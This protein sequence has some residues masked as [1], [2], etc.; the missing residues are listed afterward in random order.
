MGTAHSV[1]PATNSTNACVGLFV[2]QPKKVF[3]TLCEGLPQ[4][5]GAELI[6]SSDSQQEG[7]KKVFFISKLSA[8][9]IMNNSSDLKFRKRIRNKRR[10]RRRRILALFHKETLLKPP[11]KPRA[12]S[13]HTHIK[14]LP[15]TVSWAF[16]LL[17]DDL[18]SHLLYFFCFSLSLKVSAFFFSECMW[19]FIHFLPGFRLDFTVLPT[20][21]DKH[22][23]WS[24][25]I[26]YR[27]Q[28]ALE[29]LPNNILIMLNVPR[30]LLRQGAS[31]MFRQEQLDSIKHC[32]GKCKYQ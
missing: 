4:E 28:Q 7:E 16:S 3:R 25:R 24:V 13:T 12:A 30:R 17:Q 10:R 5:M 18:C 23:V 22:F 6:F 27:E 11:D 21:Q 19:V 2:R 14:F 29:T 26:I 20:A 1:E 8:D 31:K 32:D 9:K 15:T